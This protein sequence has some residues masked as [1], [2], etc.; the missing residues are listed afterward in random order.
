[1]GS[2]SDEHVERVRVRTHLCAGVEEA[3]L[4]P[5]RSSF[6]GRAG[7]SRVTASH[8]LSPGEGDQPSRGCE[9]QSVPLKA[10][11][12]VLQRPGPSWQDGPQ[13]ALRE[14]PR[15][16][17]SPPPSPSGSGARRALP[18]T[19]TFD[20]QT[21]SVVCPVTRISGPMSVTGKTTSPQGEEIGSPY[22]VGKSG[23]QS[24]LPG[25][26]RTA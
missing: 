25:K 19:S 10:D 8:G 9:P 1:M 7:D 15:P 24:F 6:L 3:F 16:W 12:W 21:A 18:R 13:A 22:E 11:T 5:A 4:H 17:P 26:G 2:G 14:D 20:S 23:L